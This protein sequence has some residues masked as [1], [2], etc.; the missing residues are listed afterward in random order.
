M[1]FSFV[2]PAVEPG[3]SQAIVVS[4]RHFWVPVCRFAAPG[5]TVFFIK[6]LVQLQES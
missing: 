5:T 1:L 3:P 2:A 4:E 6:F